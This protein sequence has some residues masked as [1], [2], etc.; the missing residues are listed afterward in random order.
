MEYVIPKIV[1]KELMGKALINS[2][3]VKGGGQLELL[4]ALLSDDRI[5]V[6]E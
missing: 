1:R 2:D 3:P 6:V 4:Q 5:K